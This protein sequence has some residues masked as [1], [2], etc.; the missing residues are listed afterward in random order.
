M[1]GVEQRTPRKQGGRRSGRRAGG[2]DT[3][4]QVLTAAKE[5]FAANGYTAT[6]IRAVAARAGVDPALV[7]YFFGSKDGLFSAAMQLPVPPAQIVEGLLAE[8]TRNL[9]ERL[10]RTFLGTWDAGPGQSPIVALI[11]SSAGN[12]QAARM[13]REFITTEVLGRVAATIDRPDPDLRAC[14]VGSQLIGL[15][16]AR[17]VVG[18]EPLASTDAESLVRW[19]APTVDRYLTG[20]PMATPAHVDL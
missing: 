19:L 5:C 20:D 1:P 18:V 17:Y 9:G 7:H 3:R 11:R 6:T 13:V 4:E 12:D 16:Y 8:G 10:V 2:Q 15:A 14:L